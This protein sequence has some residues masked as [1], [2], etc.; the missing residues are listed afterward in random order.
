MISL[1]DELL[2]AVDAEAGRLGTTRSGLLRGLAQSALRERGL[3]RAKR[4][5]ELMGGASGHG[6]AVAEVLECHR[7]RR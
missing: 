5:E 3:E 6:G 7:P 4:I 1:P 2:N